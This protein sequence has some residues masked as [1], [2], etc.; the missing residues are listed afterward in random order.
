[1]NS[2]RYGASLRRPECL[3]IMN[4]RGRL[5]RDSMRAELPITPEFVA[6]LYMEQEKDDMTSRMSQ[7]SP[8][9]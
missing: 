7:P 4:G 9:D 2:F 3:S 6:P 5:E 8:T 1:M